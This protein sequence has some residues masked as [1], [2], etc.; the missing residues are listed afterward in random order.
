MLQWG[1]ISLSEGL[2]N[3]NVL[4]EHSV[5]DSMCGGCIAFMIISCLICIF[6]WEINVK[7]MGLTRQ[8]SLCISGST[9]LSSYGNNI[10]CKGPQ[11]L[12]KPWAVRLMGLWVFPASWSFFS[13]LD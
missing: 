12:Q 9:K 4:V 7:I 10:V 8:Y 6:Y 2:V 3:C 13:E 5:I 11:K 1:L